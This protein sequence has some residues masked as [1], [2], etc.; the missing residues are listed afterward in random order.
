MS[1]ALNSSKS[2]QAITIL[3]KVI[4]GLTDPSI[5]FRGRGTSFRLGQFRTLKFSV[6]LN[7]FQLHNK[8]P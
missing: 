4:T 5:K 6:I 7:Y 8:F 1:C 2:L 3:S